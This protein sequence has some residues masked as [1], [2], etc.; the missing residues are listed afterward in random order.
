MKN[1]FL[2]I[3]FFICCICFPTIAQ[4]IITA[5]IASTVNQTVSPTVTITYPKAYQHVRGEINIYGKAK[6]GAVVKLNITS[7]YF[8]KAY[9]QE[10]ITKGEG[11]IKRLNRKFTLKAD[12]TGN[13]ILKNV[14]F[15]NAGWEEDYTIEAT[16]DGK[17]VKVNVQDHTHPVAID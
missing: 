3:Y 7:T 6:P 14:E 16:V 11:P 4:Q 8:K 9:N 17:S 2:I 5:P 15:R 12:K 1:K 10:R 13:W